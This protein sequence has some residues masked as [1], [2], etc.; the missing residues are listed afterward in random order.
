M[1]FLR[2]LGLSALLILPQTMSAAPINVCGIMPALSTWCAT[3]GISSGVLLIETTLMDAAMNI[4][5]GLS[6]LFFFY[7]AIRLMLESEDEST[8]GETKSAYSYA[9]AGCII[10]SM[11]NYIR[12]AVGVGVASG[13]LINT[14]PVL[15]GVSNI[16]LFIRLIIALCVT[17]AIV[18]SGFRLIVLQGQESEMEQQKKRFFYGLLGVAVILLAETIITAF[19]PPSGASV[20]AV[21]IVGIINFLLTIMGALAVLAFIVA[22]IMLVFSTTDSLKDRAKKT[23]FTTVIALILVIVSYVIIKFTIDVTSA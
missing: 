2:L 20:L 1:R 10:V 8:I 12:N 22:G 16:I 6:L 3:G 19:L 18:Y 14:A 17:G 9:I 11:V 13:T 5:F 21:Q 4:F 23:M 7:Y 15:T